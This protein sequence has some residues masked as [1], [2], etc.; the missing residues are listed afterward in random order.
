MFEN[1]VE[2]YGA[3]ANE[4]IRKAKISQ[5][6]SW[7]IGGFRRKADYNYEKKLSSTLAD[8][9]LSH[10]FT[11]SFLQFKPGICCYKNKFKKYQD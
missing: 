6:I 4:Q 3:Q 7:R 8:S 10:H 5:G 1:D 11:A 9:P 2:M